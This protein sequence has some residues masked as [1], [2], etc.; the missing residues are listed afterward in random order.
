LKL[1]IQQLRRVDYTS[2]KT[3]VALEVDN[4]DPKGQERL[5]DKFN[6][7]VEKLITK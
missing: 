2:K 7:I 1:T 4:T 6:E 5:F 3:E